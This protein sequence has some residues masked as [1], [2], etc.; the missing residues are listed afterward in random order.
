ME[1]KMRNKTVQEIDFQGVPLIV[2]DSKVIGF[3][4]DLL[5]TLGSLVGIP[6]E[7]VPVALD[8]TEETPKPKKKPRKVS[9]RHDP[10]TPIAEAHTIARYVQDAVVSFWIMGD[11]PTTPEEVT[12][13]LPL[14]HPRDAKV[15]ELVANGGLRKYVNATLGS[16]WKQKRLERPSKAQY[17]P[18]DITI[19][20]YRPLLDGQSE[21]TFR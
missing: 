19:S 4:I 18:S 12:N 1:N 2:V 20:A 11:N 3:G 7:E 14:K 13:Y 21:I 16:L 10:T 5:P 9:K 6:A 17:E 15:Q 8:F